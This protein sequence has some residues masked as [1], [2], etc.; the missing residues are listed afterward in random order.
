MRNSNYHIWKLVSTSILNAFSV[1]LL[2]YYNPTKQTNE[3]TNK[4]ATAIVF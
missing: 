4:T 1:P 3:Q 2:L